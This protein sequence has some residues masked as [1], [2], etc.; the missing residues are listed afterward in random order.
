M[1]T[2]ILIVED[3]ATLRETLA[4]NLIKEGHDVAKAS[5]GAV[6]LEMARV[7]RFDLIVLD[8]MLPGLDGLSFCRIIRK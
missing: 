5:D 7:T 2:H 6:A 8:I 3:D 1:A 4:Y